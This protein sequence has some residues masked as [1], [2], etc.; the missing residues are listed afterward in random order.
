MLCFQPVNE[1]SKVVEEPFIAYLWLKK[2]M[3]ISIDI[4]IFIHE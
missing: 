2:Y 4:S 3:D 1:P